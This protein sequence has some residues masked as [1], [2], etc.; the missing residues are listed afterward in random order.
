[1]IRIVLTEICN[2]HYF[3]LKKIYL[4]YIKKLGCISDHFYVHSPYVSRILF[5]PSEVHAG[6]DAPPPPAPHPRFFWVFFLEDKTSAPDV[7]SSCSFIPRAHFKSSLVMVS[8]YG[9]EIWRQGGQAIFEWKCML[10]T[11]FKWILWLKPCIVLIHVLFF[12]S[13]IKKSPFLAVLT[14]CLILGKIQDSG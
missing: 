5:Q 12:M 9:Y 3:L 2:T 1:M 6:A 7:F 10:S 8:F 11:F 13:S 4:L 14:W